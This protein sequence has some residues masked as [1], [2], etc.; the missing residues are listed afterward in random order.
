VVLSDGRDD[1][2]ADHALSVGAAAY[3]PTSLPGRDLVDLLAT[4][5]TPPEAVT[6]W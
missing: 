2:I 1:A 6:P 5:A 3:A 4:L